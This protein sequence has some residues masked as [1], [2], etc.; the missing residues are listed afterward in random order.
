MKQIVHHQPRGMHI[1]PKAFT[2]TQ[3]HVNDWAAA[4]CGISISE[5]DWAKADIANGKNKVERH[6]TEMLAAQINYEAKVSQ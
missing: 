5:S 3:Q 2:P 1:P 4:M 6:D